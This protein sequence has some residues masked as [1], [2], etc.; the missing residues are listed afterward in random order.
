MYSALLLDFTQSPLHRCIDSN[1]FLFLLELKTQKIIAIEFITMQIL[2]NINYPLALII[3]I[4]L[5]INYIP[6]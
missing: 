2:I 4:N 1:S 5:L 6:Y 3:D